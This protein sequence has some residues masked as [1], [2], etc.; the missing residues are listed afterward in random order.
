MFSLI[1]FIVLEFTD[2]AAIIKPRTTE[3]QNQSAISQEHQTDISEPDDRNSSTDHE[4]SSTYGEVPPFLSE[5]GKSP[6]KRARSPATWSSAARKAMAEKRGS[7]S[8]ATD[9][10]NCSLTFLYNPDTNKVEAFENGVLL[11][12]RS[13]TKGPVIYENEEEVLSRKSLPKKKASTKIN[14]EDNETSQEQ[15]VQR[16]LLENGSKALYFSKSYFILDRN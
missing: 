9:P 15:R 11:E 10:E 8:A 13:P 14:R 3:I 6:A 5:K 7:T 16:T 1:L 12:F 4:L 2:K